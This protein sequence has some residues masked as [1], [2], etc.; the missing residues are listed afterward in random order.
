MRKVS[1]CGDSQRVQAAA[2][3]ETIN[4]TRL[5]KDRYMLPTR[6]KRMLAVLGFWI[7]KMETRKTPLMPLPITMLTKRSRRGYLGV[8]LKVGAN[9]EK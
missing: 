9:G 4:I 7:V 3:V 6:R 5:E 1:V 8:V 2:R